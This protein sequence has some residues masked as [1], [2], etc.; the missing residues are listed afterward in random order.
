[1]KVIIYNMQ[2]HIHTILK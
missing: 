1:V 2:Y